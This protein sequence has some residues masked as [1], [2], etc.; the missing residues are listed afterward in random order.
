MYIFLLPNPCKA[1]EDITMYNFM[2][3]NA[4]LFNNQLVLTFDVKLRPQAHT[5]VTCIN[6]Y[7]MNLSNEV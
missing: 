2:V 4:F 5:M 1:E 3:D 7:S 6:Y